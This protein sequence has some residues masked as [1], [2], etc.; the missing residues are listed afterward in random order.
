[1]E[2]LDMVP[3]D[4]IA[5][6]LYSL[7]AA[8]AAAASLYYAWLVAALAAAVGLWRIR[9]VSA[10]VRR[11]SAIVD[12]KSKAQS[13]SPSP[14]IEEPRLAAPAEPA[15][16]SGEPSTPSKVRFTVYYG[17]SGDADDGVVDGVRRCADDDDRVDGEVD[18]VLRRTASAPERRRAKALAAAAPWEEREMAVRRRGDLGWYRHL[19]MAALD[20][21]VV[22]L[23]DGELTAS[24]RA[25]RRRAGLELQ[26]SF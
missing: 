8:V 21:S 16:P 11:G 24:P 6:R 23:W 9:A 25:R 14:A 3:A 2:L 12:D 7:P 22:K 26:L 4:A 13:P 1:M 19:D 5:L 20:G 18:A 15:S 10:G 17:V